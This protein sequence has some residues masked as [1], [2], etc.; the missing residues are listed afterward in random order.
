MTATEP[1]VVMKGI[2]IEFPGVKA[3]DG[4]DLRL[5]PGEV[6]ALM[7]ENGA[8]KSTMIKALT[9]VYKINA[10]SITVAG[11]PVTFSGTAD[12]QQAGVAT[13]YQEVNL[14]T[15]L[16]IGE[17]VMLGHE[18]RGP[19]GIDWRK[20]HKE[21]QKHLSSMGLSDLDPRA[22]LSSISIAMQQLVAIARAM[23]I[24]AK[25]LILDEPTSSL[26]ANEVQ[27][28][29][30]IMRKVR[31]SGVAILFVS[32]FLDQIYEITD[33]LT[34][35]RNGQFIKE[36]MTKET[37]RAELIGM[38]IGKSAEELSQ[39]GAK[40]SRRVSKEGEKPIV[41]VKGLGHKGKIQ[42]TDEQIYAGEVVGF[43][44]LLGSG[45]T[46]LGR[47][48]F[49]ADKPETGE[50]E[51]NGK[52]IAINDPHTALKNRIAYST[53]NRRDEGIIG[54]LTVRQNIL[55]ALQATR[56]M[57]RPIAKK[58]ADAIV[59]KYMKELNVR[60]ADP[61]KLI[62]N[63]SGGNQ[64]KVLLARWLAT[65]PELLILD[66]PTRGIDIGAK[67][68]IQQAVL[69]L[70]QQ[71]MGV[72][73]ISSELEEVVRLSDNI[74]VLKDHKKIADIV[75]DETVSQ[76]TIVDTIARSGKEA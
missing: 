7:G 1:I 40:K 13:V 17:N 24:D 20:T 12:A 68:E 55:I 25:V 57:F 9:G 63:L 44:G 42:P 53:E 65:N 45:R 43:A 61:D 5:F 33:R 75:N 26:D 52:K 76:E 60:P 69:D 15:N 19:F 41:Q 23:V 50:Y 18:I 39:I 48:L 11:K 73:F 37:P 14:C 62:K 36:V 67:A 31:D 16:S 8:G 46:E 2:T 54:D 47:L 6:H 66:E 72:V 58:E 29:F 3:L 32:H 35:L 4:V 21:A 70:A 64:Q 28:L 27:E 56:G 30:A 49:G 38:M 59:D 34:I 10:G 71:G 51:L 22:P 74:T